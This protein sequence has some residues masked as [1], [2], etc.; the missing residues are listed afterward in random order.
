MRERI[1]N[2][3][4]LKGVTIINPENT[5]IESGV[6]VGKDS[7][8]YPGAILTGNTIVGGENCIIGENSR[9]EDSE[10]GNQVEV[11][12]STIT[13]S[14]VGHGCTIGPY[15]HL[16]PNCYLGK[17]IKIGNFVEVKNSTI[18]DGGLRHPI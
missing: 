6:S 12:S 2:G 9:I 7:I 8:I 16:R 10:I 11:Y 13:E 5:Y 1:N 4:M 14:K 18:G 17:D 3:H 15:A